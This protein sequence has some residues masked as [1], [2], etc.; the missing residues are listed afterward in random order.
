MGQNRAISVS[1]DRTQWPRR[2]RWRCRSRFGPDYKLADNA[3]ADPLWWEAHAVSPTVQSKDDRGYRE[4][5]ASN[6][7]RAGHFFLLL[8]S[9]VHDLRVEVR[10]I[11]STHHWRIVILISVD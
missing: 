6:P 9:F 4:G 10:S 3:C 7:G 5:L 8:F 1:C 11:R 2:L